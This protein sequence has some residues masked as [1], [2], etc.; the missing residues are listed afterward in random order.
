MKGVG[1]QELQ[2]E[3]ELTSFVFASLWKVRLLTFKLRFA[4]SV[5]LS[6]RGVAQ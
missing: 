5:Q 4:V 1:E 2:T 6:A 3:V